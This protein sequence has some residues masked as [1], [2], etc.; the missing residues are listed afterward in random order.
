MG[1][2]RSSRSCR[3]S[4]RK[5]AERSIKIER[6]GRR[7]NLP[8]DFGDACN[9]RGGHSSPVA[10]GNRILQVPMQR[11][12]FAFP[13]VFAYLSLVRLSLSIPITGTY[14]M[15]MTHRKAKQSRLEVELLFTAAFIVAL[16]SGA[17]GQTPHQA[18]VAREISRTQRPA[19]LHAKSEAPSAA[20]LRPC[21]RERYQPTSP[22]RKI[23][24]STRPTPSRSTSHS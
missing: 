12:R 5:N 2:R 16:L 24:G 22:P 21:R 19:P 1:Y 4:R 7:T 17:E 13:P 6:F 18:E 11:I 9:D 23:K 15:H 10:V 8:T 3:S 14:K 20:L